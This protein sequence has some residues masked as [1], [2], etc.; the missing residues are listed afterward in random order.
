MARNYC[1]FKLND[2]TNLAN[3]ALGLA[4]CYI[5][6]STLISSCIFQHILML[7]ELVK[8]IIQVP[9]LLFVHY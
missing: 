1:N 5:C 9:I 4:L 8:Y 7:S 6:H 2:V 3:I